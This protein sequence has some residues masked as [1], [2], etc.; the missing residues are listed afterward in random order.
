MKPS[1]ED[2]SKRECVPDSRESVGG[3]HSAFLENTKTTELMERWKASILW[4]QTHFY[5]L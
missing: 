5:Y 2:R 4:L 3:S 1:M